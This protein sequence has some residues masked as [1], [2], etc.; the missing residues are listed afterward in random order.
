VSPYGGHTVR[1]EQGGTFSVLFY[2]EGFLVRRRKT[3][4]TV[5]FLHRKNDQGHSQPCVFAECHA[6][7]VVIGPVWGHGE[8][9]VRRVLAQLSTECECPAAYHWHKESVGS[10][11][12]KKC[13][14]R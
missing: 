7:S 11:I 13:T 4:A 10:R 14:R 12:P 9:S 8:A 6:S 1:A 5:H 2:L 3:S